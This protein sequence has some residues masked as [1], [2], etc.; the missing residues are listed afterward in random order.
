MSIKDRFFDYWTTG[1]LSSYKYNLS[2]F[3]QM[4]YGIFGVL[5]GIIVAIVVVV[6]FPIWCIPYIIYKSLQIKRAR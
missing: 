6:T 5:G 1:S 3:E 4:V 2:I